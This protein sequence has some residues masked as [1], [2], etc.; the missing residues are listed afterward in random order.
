MRLFANLGRVTKLSTL[1]AAVLHDTIE[2]TDTEAEEI[3]GLFGLTVRRLVE[4]L[5]D[6]K[7]LP[8]Q[9]RKQLQIDHARGL[10]RAAKEIKLAD[11]ISNV[12]DV[13]RNPPNK[14]SQKRREKYLDWAENV[15]AGCRGVNPRLEREFDRVLAEGRKVLGRRSRAKSGG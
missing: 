9:K 8:K 3:Q 7:S 14:W 12:G 1:V 5:T 13:T 2:D 6:D 15:I 10:S 4:E 11:K